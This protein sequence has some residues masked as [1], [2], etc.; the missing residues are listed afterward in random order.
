MDPDE[1]VQVQVTFEAVQGRGQGLLL[2]GWA[3]EVVETGLGVWRLFVWDQD[4]A[5]FSWAVGTIPASFGFGT[6][7]SR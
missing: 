1:D 3:A 4:F 6:T 5:G 2:W 7:L